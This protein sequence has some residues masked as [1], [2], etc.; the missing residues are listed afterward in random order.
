MA[1]SNDIPFDGGDVSR[2]IRDRVLYRRNY[3]NYYVLLCSDD[4]CATRVRVTYLQCVSVCTLCI[5]GY[6]EL[7]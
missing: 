7:E 5:Y 1:F 4:G 6:I 2:G 3:I